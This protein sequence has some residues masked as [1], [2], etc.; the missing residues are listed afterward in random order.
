MSVLKVTG[1]TDLAGLGGFT[2]SSGSITCNGTLRVTDININ[3]TITG[4][5]NYNIPSFSGQSGQ[6]LSTN[7]TNLIWSSEIT[8]GGSGGAGF[9]S[10]QVWT[11]NGTWYRPSDVKSIKVQVVGAGGG[12]SGKCESGGAGGFSERVIDVS[13]VSSVGVSVGNPGGG[14]SYA[15]CGGNGNGSSFGG[16]CSASAGI[17]ANCSQQH[18]GGYGGNG[19]GGNMNA[20]GGGGNGYGNWSKYGNYTSGASYMGGSQPA[21]H[22]QQDYS[23]RHQ[24]HC[25]WGAGGNGARE[26]TRGARGRE[27]VVVVYEYYG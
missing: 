10:M 23:H 17:G 24:S 1:V 2:L 21:S 3:G 6:F 20:Y 15:G 25:A 16:Y 7:G 4:S 8:G 11:S 12:G 13:N 27:G 5:S 9:R 14:T 19:S 26:G 22:Q 18:A